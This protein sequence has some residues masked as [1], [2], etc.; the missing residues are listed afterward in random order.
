MENVMELARGPSMGQ[1]FARLGG[2]IHENP[3]SVKRGF[4]T[5]VPASIAG[6]A[7]RASTPDGA[8][9]LLSTLRRGDY[10][11]ID[12][13]ELER[14]AAD[15]LATE[16]IARS[17]EGFLR[18]LFG[19]KESVI[20]DGLAASSGVSR[21]SAS[22]VLGLASQL[23]LGF[24]GREAVTRNMDASGLRG[25]L[26]SLRSQATSAMPGPLANLFSSP[27]PM[28]GPAITPVRQPSTVGT[29]ILAGVV[30]L[31]AIGL[32]KWRRHSH[33]QAARTSAMEASQTSSEG[34]AKPVLLRA[35]PG[36]AAL[37]QALDGSESLPARFVLGDLTFRADSA[38]IEPASAGVL[39]DVARV[40]STH[41]TSRIRVE[42]H[43]DNTGTIQKSRRL[44]QERAESAR[45]YLLGKGIGGDRVTSAGFGPDSPIASNATAEGRA[46]NRRTEL[47]LLQ[48]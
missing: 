24:V 5:A 6:L 18:R 16:S 25:F 13:D 3:E 46:E 21:S 15:Q 43:S 12:E 9:S 2:W 17:G 33:E 38:E 27:A 45:A 19:S 35:G 34:L 1:V 20:V 23:V 29:W 30:A 26:A 44:S 42:G 37:S 11:H 36:V 22:K 39:D 32:L 4:E 10:P 7:E 8:Q 47:V 40:L 28:Q 14:T 31:G 41:P 48:R